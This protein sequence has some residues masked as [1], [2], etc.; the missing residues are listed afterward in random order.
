MEIGASQINPLFSE[1]VGFNVKF[2]AE[3]KYNLER[4]FKE[5][6]E[7]EKEKGKNVQ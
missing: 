6:L 3:V 4:Y 5:I 7:K 1:L 2:I